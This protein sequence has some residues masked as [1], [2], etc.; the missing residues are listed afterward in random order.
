MHPTLTTPIP[1]PISTSTSTS[2]KLN[3]CLAQ[4]QPQLV[5][6]FSVEV[7]C[8]EIEY[9]WLWQSKT[10]GMKRILKT[11]TQLWHIPTSTKIEVDFGRKMTA[12]HPN[13]PTQPTQ[14]NTKATYKHL[15]TIVRY[16]V[17][18]FYWNFLFVRFYM[19][20]DILQLVVSI[21]LH[22]SFLEIS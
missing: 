17:F 12:Y 2:T 7:E 21:H 11:P 6:W 10:G 5:T 22:I 8:H 20:T 14:R 15:L 1:T 4:L 13:P 9:I 19:K 3:F 18:F 16:K